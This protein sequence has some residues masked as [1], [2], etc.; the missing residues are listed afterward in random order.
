[1]ILWQAG[2]FAAKPTTDPT[3]LPAQSLAGQWQ[4]PHGCVGNACAGGGCQHLHRHL[5]GRP[6]VWAKGHNSVGRLLRRFWQAGRRTKPW[7]FSCTW[8]SWQFFGCAISLGFQGSRFRVSALEFRFKAH[9]RT[10]YLD[11][12]GRDHRGIRWL[13][14]VDIHLYIFRG[15]CHNTWRIKWKRTWKT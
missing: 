12:Q 2:T 3:G 15:Y 10:V 5:P 14:Q 4:W 13:D 9:G 1:M 7:A 8:T 11:T 6:I